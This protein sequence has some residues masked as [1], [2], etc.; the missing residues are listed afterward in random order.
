M[1]R[2]VSTGLSL[3]MLMTAC[4]S[5]TGSAASTPLPVPCEALAMAP[6]PSREL[7][8]VARHIE[9]PDLGPTGVDI[10]LSVDGGRSWKPAS[11]TG[12]P[13][14]LGTAYPDVFFS[15][16]Y[17]TDHR[18]YIQEASSGLFVS[19]DR[20]QTF[21]VADPLAVNPYSIRRLSPFWFD[22]PVPMAGLGR[23]A[24]IAYAGNPSAILM[25]PQHLPAISGPADVAR[26]VPANLAQSTMRIFAVTKTSVSVPTASVL[27]C[28]VT[29]V[30]AK[31]LYT[32]SSNYLLMS[33]DISSAE[34]AQALA[35]S[36]ELVNFGTRRVQI[37][38]LDRSGG[39]KRNLALEAI[40]ATRAR[41]DPAAARISVVED[42]K[43][44]AWTARLSCLALDGPC[45]SLYRSLDR[46]ASWRQMS[47]NR[48][49]S[50]WD[51]GV[52]PARGTGDITDA[53]TT[54]SGAHGEIY[55]I[56]SPEGTFRGLAGAFYCSTD[57]GRTWHVRCR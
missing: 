24:A 39:V 41:R 46:G 22:S 1:R 26:F 32:G 40:V 35:A 16:A 33:V 56:G 50:S 52:L 55:L 5:T 45:D 54:W 13:T 3:A 7:V 20:G 10:A 21:T 27:E 42:R 17:T 51:T 37:L 15:L 29:L 11:G 57:A 14:G 31:A 38:T 47:S 4:L 12:L 53:A 49:V 30:C 44:G 36:I 2:T 6:A 48:H 34:R 8:C 28:T 43:S 25:P 19:N 23:Q 9:R 18:L